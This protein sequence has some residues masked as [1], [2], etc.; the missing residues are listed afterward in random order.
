MSLWRYRQKAFTYII[1]L[2]RL[3]DKILKRAAACGIVLSGLSAGAFC[4]FTFGHSDSRSFAKKSNWDYI[5]VRGLEIV[6]ALYCPHYHAEKRERS[7]SDMIHKRGGIA[8]ACDNN[9]A[10]EIVGSSYRVLVSSNEAK[11]YK[12]Y[13]YKG[14]IIKIRLPSNTKYKSLSELCKKSR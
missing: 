7:V 5:R 13:K 12:I 11:A 6:N 9:A 14:R 10:I 3:L 4:W 2:D 8:L 1:K